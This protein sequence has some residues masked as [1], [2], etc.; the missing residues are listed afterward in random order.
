[1]SKPGNKP[2]WTALV[3]DH[4]IIWF[5]GYVERHRVLLRDYAR[6]VAR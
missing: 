6:E 5:E 3:T 4:C 2:H 1:M